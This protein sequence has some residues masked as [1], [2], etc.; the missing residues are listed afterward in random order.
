MLH[1]FYTWPFGAVENSESYTLG[2]IILI[3]NHSL[4]KKIKY[5]IHFS[6]PFDF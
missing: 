4:L 3:M 6:V 1:Y 5:N 2:N